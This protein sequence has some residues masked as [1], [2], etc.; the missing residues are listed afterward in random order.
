MSAK[1]QTGKGVKSFIIANP[2]YDTVFKRL[3]ENRRIAR[4]FLS[5]ILEQQITDL[6]VL[7][8]E[9]TYKY[10]S[11][12]ER[13]SEK[14][15]YSI[16]RMDF[17]ATVQTED[18]AQKRILIEVQ[19]SWDRDDVMRFR[20]YLGEQ[21]AKRDAADGGGAMLPITT[22][23]ILG[24][25]LAEIESPCV[26]VGRTYT[27][28]RNMETIHAKSK[29]MELLTH[30]SYVIQAG[31]ITD[32]RYTTN[33]DKLLSIFE[34][35]YFVRND[36]GAVKEYRHHPDDE[37]MELITSVLYEMVAD[38]KERKRLEDEEEAMRILD[39]VYF[40]KIRDRESIIGKKEMIIEEQA[41]ALGEKDKILE[42]Q[43]GQIAELKRL[44]QG[45][46]VE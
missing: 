33:L 18:G 8:Q 40:S 15:P 35:A 41:K 23:Y 39:I 45:K 22:I 43:A 21:Y 26:K 27:D 19:K 37:N 25:N 2:L 28:M 4:F 13:E 46:Q 7:P 36:S 29:F 16:L 9:F 34:Q 6:T 17:T 1:E 32:M 10:K 30:D 3:M 38:P 14:L 31:R 24:T 5:T 44:L 20:K 11:N 12:A 42:E